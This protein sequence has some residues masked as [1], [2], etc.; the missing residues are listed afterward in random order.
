MLTSVTSL[1]ISGTSLFACL[2]ALL[3][4]SARERLGSLFYLGPFAL[5]LG[6]GFLPASGLMVWR[7]LL[8]DL[9][10][11]VG[12]LYLCWKAPHPWPLWAFGLQLLAVMAD[13]LD[14]VMHGAVLK[15][16]IVTLQNSLGYIILF[17]LLWGTLAAVRR[18][19][20]EGQKSNK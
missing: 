14:L 11:L 19:G 7:F 2:L 10:C 1:A 9:L 8:C 17:V 5:S 16:T 6:L 3:F 20:K 13:I 4:G 15:W 18:R 12:F